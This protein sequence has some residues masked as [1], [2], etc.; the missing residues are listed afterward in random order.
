MFACIVRI[1][2]YKIVMQL[3]FSEI[4]SECHLPVGVK[5]VH[6]K[7]RVKRDVGQGVAVLDTTEQF[8]SVDIG[9]FDDDRENERLENI[10]N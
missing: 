2:K 7:F 4:T 8:R 1:C 3:Q 10:V 9:W 6:D 5:W